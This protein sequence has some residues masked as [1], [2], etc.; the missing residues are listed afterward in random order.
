MNVMCFS[1]F[2]LG[3]KKNMCAHTVSHAPLS[4]LSAFFLPPFFFEA[5]LIAKFLPSLLSPTATVDS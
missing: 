3:G 1:S 4:Q 2:L 5:R